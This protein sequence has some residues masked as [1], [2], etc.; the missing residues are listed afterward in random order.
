M[1]AGRGPFSTFV[2]LYTNTRRAT[3]VNT[4]TTKLQAAFTSVACAFL[5]YTNQTTP[6]RAVGARAVV[7]VMHRQRAR[8]TKARR[9]SQRAHTTVRLDHGLLSA[10][11]NIN[12]H[13]FFFPF[14]GANK[15][16]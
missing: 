5:E 9:I 1:V 14:F 2:A 15:K 8:R 12:L 6:I 16:I 13:F 11:V 3:K 10:D 4:D 7:C